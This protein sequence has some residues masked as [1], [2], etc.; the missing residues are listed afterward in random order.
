MI[1]I[2]SM[3]IK[4]RI[5][6]RKT[7]EMIQIIKKADK[8]GHL[9]ETIKEEFF[10]PISVTALWA[11]REYFHKLPEEVYHQNTGESMALISLR[12]L[13]ATM[14]ND[15]E[16]AKAYIGIFGET[17]KNISP[18]DFS[19]RDYFCLTAQLVM[20]YISDNEFFHVVATMQRVNISQIQSLTLSASRPSI[21]NGFRDFTRYGKELIRYRETITN[22]VRMLYGESGNGV[23]EIAL[24]EW[25][26]QINDSF[27]AL[28]LVTGTIPMMENVQDMQCLFVAM[29][30]QMKILLLNGQSQAA[31]PLVEKIRERIKKTGW[32]ELTNSLNALGA[33]AA[34]YDGNQDIVQE[35]LDTLA[36]DETKELYMMDMYAYLVK[37][38]CYLMTGKYMLAIIF[39]K[40]L[41]PILKKGYRH[42]DVCECYM[43]SAI[44]CC[45][46]GA[47][48]DMCAE[49]EEALKIAQ[50][51]QYIRLLADE[52]AYMVKMLTIYHKRKE[53]NVFTEKILLL[54]GEVAKRLPDYLKSAEEYFEPL[55]VT[56]K[57]VLGLMA[58]GLSYQEIGKMTGKKVGTVK[59]HS[60]GIFRKLQV[61]NRQQ[62]V[63]R[64]NEIGLI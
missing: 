57:Q 49:L 26:Y 14:E 19:Q 40:Q 23:F 10:R 54:A 61:K 64:A 18:E 51:Y 22:M 44:A 48:E 31:Q 56:E 27:R 12:A 60:A 3:L 32:E 29:A 41:I 33:W 30:L 50:K 46:A 62:A 39:A 42:M 17:Q 24:A 28:L 13:L 38:R 35:W 16:G 1:R 59:F 9:L 21:L 55:T 37:I 6:P 25:H 52:G 4:D 34:C 7:K 5:Y 8:E 15:L 11:C 43:L 20:P 58:Q 2:E 36:P 63:N 47:L 45:K 53:S